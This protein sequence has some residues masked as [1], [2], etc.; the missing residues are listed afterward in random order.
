MAD[1]WTLPKTNWITSDGIGYADL[2]RVEANISANRDANFLRVQGF[3]YTVDNTVVGEDGVVTVLPGA[4]YTTNA[5]PLKMVANFVKNLTTWAAGNGAAFGGMAPAVTVAATTWY[6]IFVIMDPTD[7]S[8][9]IMFDDNIAGT[10]ISSGTYTEKRF[11]NSFKTNLA[12][13]DGSFD[14]V[15]MYST[16]D[17]VYIN[18]NSMHADRTVHYLNGPLI[19]GEYRTIILGGG[20]TLEL[21]SRKILAHLIAEVFDLDEVGVFSRVGSVFT[22]PTDLI[23]G[24]VRNA[25]FLYMRDTGT[26]DKTTVDFDIMIDIDGEIS[27]ARKGDTSTGY[28]GLA[29]RGFTDERLLI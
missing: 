29:A 6:Y 1:Y 12:G 26:T 18:P 14:L 25:E 13:D 4:A 11:V 5:M 17:D 3:G 20:V 9:E 27:L 21:P 28:V 7:G 8:T 24:A 15:E 19:D 2:N 23:S 16:G 10:N 22:I